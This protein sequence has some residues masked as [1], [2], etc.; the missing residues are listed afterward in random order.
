MT[1]GEQAREIIGENLDA[2]DYK[3]QCGKVVDSS[4][5]RGIA[6][7]ELSLKSGHI[8]SDV[9]LCIEERPVHHS[10]LGLAGSRHV[11]AS[12]SARAASMYSLGSAMSGRHS[13]LRS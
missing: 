4:A 12:A 11:G 9:L 6:V 8:E 7:R 3:V 10:A 2:C 5:A 1:A 13:C